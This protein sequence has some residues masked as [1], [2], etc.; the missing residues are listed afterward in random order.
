MGYKRYERDTTADILEALGLIAET[1][2]NV[3]AINIRSKEI[4]LDRED[5]KAAA[6]QQ[7]LLKEYYDKKSAIR[8]TEDMYNKYSNLNPSDISKGGMDIVNIIDEQNNIDIDAIS[9]NLDT[10]TNY[11][12]ELE[13]GLNK[14]GG[15]PFGYCGKTPGTQGA[16]F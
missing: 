13:V 15:K 2:T 11:K 12:S 14:A 1:A 7:I 5:R 10:M 8:Q 16:G 4:A 3:H 9:R 6:A